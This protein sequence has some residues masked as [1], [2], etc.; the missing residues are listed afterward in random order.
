MKRDFT[1]GLLVC[2]LYAVLA[3]CAT[4][5]S[6]YGL[7]P[8]YPKARHNFF[9]GNIAF[10]EV[11]SLQPT[12]KWESFTNPQGNAAD[13]EN[14]MQQT[15]NVTYDLK[16]WRAGGKDQ[17]VEL[18]YEQKGLSV[19]SHKVGNPLQPATKYLW[20]VRARFEIDGKPRV[21]EWGNTKFGEFHNYDII[22]NLNF[23]RFE[24]PANRPM[25]E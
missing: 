25:Q 19:P 16:I 14:Q 12:L 23:Y 4:E 18:I 24:T 13:H 1:Q 6:V 2:L 20:T 15:G 10:S 7:K 3:G 9:P 5:A 17:P 11:D 21:T 8:E 22:P